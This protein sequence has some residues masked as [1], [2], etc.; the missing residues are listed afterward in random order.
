MTYSPAPVDRRGMQHI[1]NGAAAYCC[2]CQRGFRS[3]ED[4]LGHRDMSMPFAV[5]TCSTTT[6]TKASPK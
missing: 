6:E 1:P 4:Y 5:R 2:L 3:V